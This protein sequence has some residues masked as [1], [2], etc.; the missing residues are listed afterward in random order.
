MPSSAIS[1][2][3]REIASAL[4]YA[5]TGSLLTDSKQAQ[6][7]T[8]L[9]LFERAKTQVGV[10]AVYFARDTPLVYFAIK[11]HFDPK[12][13][14]NLHRNAWNDARVPLLFVISKSEVRVYDAFAP[15]TLAASEVDDESRLLSK[16]KIT[17]RILG[18]LK[19]FQRSEVEAGILWSKTPN[20][21][22]PRVRCD[23]SLL[24]NL[25]T[26][27]KRLASEQL[28]SLIVQRLMSRLILILYLE[29]RGVLDKQYYSRFSVKISSIVDALEDY[30]LTYKIF[31][32]LAAHF[33]GDLFPVEEEEL[34]AVN[35][36]HLALLSNLFRGSDLDTGQMSLW[37]L[38]DFS[39]IPIQLISAIHETFLRD[40][41]EVEVSDESLDNVITE[42][43][44]LQT[45]K[46]DNSIGAFY[47]PIF[48][49]ELLM[50]EVLPWPGPGTTIVPERFKILDPACGSGIFLV[51]AYRRLVAHW[52]FRNSGSAPSASQL[53]DLM[54]ECIHGIDTDPAAVRIAAFSLY[55]A[56]LE[57]LSNR[58]IWE[59]F[60]F[61]RLTRSEPG[62]LPNIQNLN[63]FDEKADK[64]IQFNLVI[65][66]PPWRRDFLPVGAKEY[67]K[68][69]GYPI[70]KEIAHAFM[71]L[72]HDRAPLGKVALLCTSKWLFNR[73]G[74]D[75]KFRRAFLRTAYVETVINLSAMRKDQLFP[76]AVG[77]A[78]AV[79]YSSIRPSIVSESILYCTPKP[80]VNKPFSLELTIDAAEL[81]WIPRADAENSDDIW[82]ALLWGSLRDL[83]LI[84][85]LKSSGSSLKTFLKQR[86]KEP[87]QWNHGRGFQPYTSK[88]RSPKAKPHKDVELAA[89]PHLKAAHV[90]R[91]AT[92][93]D[94]LEEAY[95]TDLFTWT[96]PKEIYKGPHILIKEGQ[97]RGRF[98]ASF[99]PFDCSFQDTITGISAPLKDTILLKALTAYLNSSL[100]SYFLFLTTSTWG[101]ER[102]RVK[103]NEVL[104]LPDAIL[105]NEKAAF[106]LATAFDR[107]LEIESDDQRKNL[108]RE[109]DL[110]VLDALGLSTGDR[111]L[112][113]DMMAYTVD[114]F[115][116]GA[117]SAAVLAPDRTALDRYVNSYSAVL[118]PILHAANLTINA[119]VYLGTPLTVVSFQRIQGPGQQDNV[120]FASNQ[121]LT[122][123]LENLDKLLIEQQSSSIYIRRC[124]KIYENNCLHII[125]PAE[126]LLWTESAGLRDAD[127]TLV[128]LIQDGSNAG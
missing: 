98:C 38:Y 14:C 81:K 105:R 92:S 95:K 110:A 76:G 13:I 27:R 121:E 37:P 46:N 2:D 66:N 33:N 68:K 22:D 35:Q 30:V 62:R 17:S 88:N 8:R 82:K 18:Q 9:Y 34:I 44:L 80:G 86:K 51:E 120:V 97:S 20:H 73:E 114:Y 32:E 122:G 42:A 84:R 55:L 63:A 77:P 39:V 58:S 100:A 52:R 43:P 24:R 23:Q 94:E 1:L 5:D 15:P 26:T 57:Y 87:E 106:L 127:E 89:L 93:A 115:Q 118:K 72:A 64:G 54:M 28:P 70:A 11:E 123:L 6:N 61:P 79:I 36:T 71:W 103:K 3:F 12:E 31:D 59:R 102:E 25:R 119:K 85:R 109:M 7:G 41:A 49:V 50:N 4:G 111:I 112:V 113:R 128:E 16:L 104:D 75:V 126:K 29:H 83:D 116:K 67:C 91:Y 45:E 69:R 40:K 47:S 48:L 74:P 60:K 108:E 90:T 117:K 124:L 10:D 101:I 96:G 53:R 125:K 107:L 99:L 21:F 78:T 65:G 19:A 56:L